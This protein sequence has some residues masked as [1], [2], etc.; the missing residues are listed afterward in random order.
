LTEEE[1]IAYT[2]GKQ[3]QC[4]KLKVKVDETS[5][6]Y[7]AYQLEYFLST[8]EEKKENEFE[9]CRFHLRSG[10]ELRDRYR[11][12]ADMET[13]YDT[14]DFIHADWGGLGGRTLA[15]VIVKYFARIVLESEN[16]T[17]EDRSLASLCLSGPGTVPFYVLT[18]YIRR[19]LGGRAETAMDHHSAYESLGVII[20]EIE[21]GGEKGGSSRKERHRILVD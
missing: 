14:V 18:A 1:R 17:V 11:N 4:L 12:F 20:R 21:K 8:E 15:P 3:V 5:P 9:L 2:F 19:R 6:D 7:I 10:A 16:S 13:E